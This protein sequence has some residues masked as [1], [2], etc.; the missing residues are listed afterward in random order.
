MPISSYQRCLLER[1]YEEIKPKKIKTKDFD[2]FTGDLKKYLKDYLAKPAP[3]PKPS[4]PAPMSEEELAAYIE[5]QQ[6]IKRKAEE[7]KIL[8]EK[9][10][11]EEE[12]IEKLREVYGDIWEVLDSLEE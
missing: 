3:R 10:M 4:T 8:N 1:L 11:L 7:F 2:G 5:E 9:I 6:E 12:R